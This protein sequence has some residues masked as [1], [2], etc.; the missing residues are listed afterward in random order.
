MN[1]LIDS[2][3]AIEILRARDQ[4]ILSKWTE[5]IISS[6]TVFYSPVTA[7]EVWAGAFTSEHPLIIRFFRPLICIATDY[8]TGRLAGELLNKF[9]KSHRLEIGDALIAAAAIQNQTALWTRNR[10]HYPMAG[11]SFY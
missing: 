7:A 2:D 1:V 4:A 8:E 5:V 6:T 9:A 10:K 3:I 11:V